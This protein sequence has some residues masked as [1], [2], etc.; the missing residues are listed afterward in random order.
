MIVFNLG[1]KVTFLFLK[2]PPILAAKFKSIILCANIVINPTLARK[3]L[4]IR[5]KAEAKD[6]GVRKNNGVSRRKQKITRILT[7]RNPDG[8]V[9]NREDE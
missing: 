1:D 6:E 5:V 8:A 4:N 7:S 3:L 9:R 2:P